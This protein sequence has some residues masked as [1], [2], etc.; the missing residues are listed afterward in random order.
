[1]QSPTRMTFHGLSVVIFL[2]FLSITLNAQNKVVIKERLEINPK[3]SHA[4]QTSAS[5]SDIPCF[6]GNINTGI[7]DVDPKD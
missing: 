6:V 2:L 7:G 3:S 1:M 4:R 5:S